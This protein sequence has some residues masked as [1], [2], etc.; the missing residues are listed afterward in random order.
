MSR[1]LSRERRDAAA[2]AD[3]LRAHEHV[4]AVDVLPPAQT[5][6]DRFELDLLCCPEAG[7]LPPA[8]AGYCAE[9]S[10]SVRDVSPQARHWQALV[11][12]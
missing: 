9:W 5:P 12:V 6:S 10:L 11:V 1:C 4:A 2:H 3:G 7:G 8:V